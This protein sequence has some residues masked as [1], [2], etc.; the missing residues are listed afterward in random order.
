VKPTRISVLVAVAVVAGGVGYV[1]VR[2]SY[3]SWPHLPTIAPFSLALVATVEVLLALSTRNRLAGK[4]GTHPVDPLAVARYAALA[5]ASSLVG[6]LA[7][8]AYAGILIYILPLR[9]A[10]DPRNDAFVAG[11]GVAA[12]VSLVIAAYTL[13]RV[14]RIKPP[15][16]PPPVPSAGPTS[17]A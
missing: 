8:G 16:A 7:A 10:P 12:G 11:V 14:C 3:S 5:K 1:V 9:D 15:K 6:A 13:E 17:G 2:L 4:P